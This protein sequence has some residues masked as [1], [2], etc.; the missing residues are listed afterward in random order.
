MNV[1]GRLSANR[2]ARHILL[3]RIL[4][5]IF[6]LP[7]LL[8][9][10]AQEKGA[11]PPSRPVT[12][13][14]S[15]KGWG[16]ASVADI[17]AVLHSVAKE[18]MAYFPERRL[19]PILVERSRK[20]PIVLYRKGPSG[21]FLVRLDTQDTYWAQYAFQFAH[22]LTHIL[23]RYRGDKNPNKWFEESVCETASLF[24]LRKMAVSWKT[25]PP[26]SNWKSFAPHLAS[27]ASKRLEK[28]KLPEGKT[29][30][31]W[32]GEHAEDLS[33]NATNRGWNGIVA[34]SLLELLEKKPEHWEAV[35]WLNAETHEEMSFG[36]YLASWRRHVPA[37]HKDF[38]RQVGALFGV[39]VAGE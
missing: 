28:F 20:G 27:Y 23:C 13:R 18:M 2:T 37:K 39:K 36:E 31:Q 30:A 3:K 29:L 4:P 21:E 19:A 9:A 15:K 35:S 33:A 11:K 17:R 38:V 7:L 6:V 1:F 22:E 10:A 14:V 32:Y 25:N 12:L 34:E 5:A 24:A 16:G 26:Y 8:T